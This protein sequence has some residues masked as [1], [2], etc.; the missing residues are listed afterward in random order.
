MTMNKPTVVTNL[1]VAGSPGSTG[2]GPL[3]IGASVYG[4]LA[5]DLQCALERGST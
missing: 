3:F 1:T 2:S 5:G 4:A